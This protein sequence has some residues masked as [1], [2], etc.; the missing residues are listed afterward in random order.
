MQL[1]EVINIAKNSELNSLAVKN[2]DTA[3]VGFINL[4]LIELYSIFALRTEEY[5]LELQDNVTIYNLPN[6]YMYMVAAYEEV[7]KG[8]DKESV[9]VPINEESNPFSINTINYKQIQ[10]PLTIKGG[11][12]SIIYVPKPE[13]MLITDLDAELP[14]PDQLVAPLLSYVAYKGHGAVK[15]E[16]QGEY[17][18]Y[19]VRFK[20]ACD[21]IKSLGVGIT[22]DDLSMAERI[23]IR[24]FV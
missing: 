23:S 18:T 9:E 10:V 2:N 14:I 5:L 13:K 24:G 15:A 16:V 11:Y 22:P 3:I 17:N 12:I 4:G 21:D 1:Q 7:P 6:D 19:Y 8:S 20:Q